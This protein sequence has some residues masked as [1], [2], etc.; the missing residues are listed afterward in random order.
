PMQNRLRLLAIV[1]LAMLVS[2][3]ISSADCP[4]CPVKGGGSPKS[5]CHVELA[6]GVLR[7]NYPFY[8]KKGK[9]IRCFDG[10]GCDL[11]GVANNSCTFDVNVCLHNPDPSLADCTP[12]TVT[13]VTVDD[14]ED[15]PALSGL[16]T[17]VNA[18]LPAST[19]VCTTGQ[20]ITIPLEGPD[21]EGV[22]A[23]TKFQMKVGT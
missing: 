3:Q 10:D 1:A 18:L 21:D 14:V 19:N 8:P 13:A 6:S 9:E 16:Q 7:A 5:D 22:Y 11:D 20:T 12:A 2:P 23:A 15:F 4:D 17:A